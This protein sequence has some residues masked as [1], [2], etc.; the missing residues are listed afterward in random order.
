M[1]YSGAGLLLSLCCAGIANA[2]VADRAPNGF[3]V[4]NTVV[5]DATPSRSWDAL[6]NEI[7]LWWPADHTWFGD[8]GTLSIDPVAGGCFC[9]RNGQQQ[10]QHLT[11]SHVD[12]GK[13]LR[14]LGG[15]GPLQ[16]MGLHGVLDFQLEALDKQRTQITMQHRVGGYSPDDLG[17]FA[18][19]VDQVQALQLNS[20]AKHL[21]AP[22]KE[23]QSP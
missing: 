18:T 10:A 21:T 4:S 11:V 17:E 9:E 8:A 20:L 19:V 7:G 14:M 3:T 6:I 5:V 22:A 16:G 15:L 13:L 1:K 2:E 23:P 12:P